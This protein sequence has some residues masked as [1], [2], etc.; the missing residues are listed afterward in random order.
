[1]ARAIAVM[2]AALFAVMQAAPAAARETVQYFSGG[3]K[4]VCPCFV[5][6][7]QIA[8]VFNAPASAYPIEITSVSVV[9]A[10]QFGVSGAFTERAVRLYLGT[11]PSLG[12]PAYSIDLPTLN[13]GSTNEFA[14][15]PIRVDAGSFTVALELA[16]SNAGMIFSP[17]VVH[18]GNGCHAGRNFV[19]TGGV[20]QDACAI[21]FTGD[22]EFLVSY[23]SL[24]PP[25]LSAAPAAVSLLD[26]P[27]NTTACATVVLANSG[28]DTLTIRG[29]AGCGNV[30]FAI[31]SSMTS[32]RL[33]PGGQTTLGICA[34]PH[35]VDPASCSVQIIHDRGGSVTIP[36]SCRPTTSVTV[37]RQPTSHQFR[38]K[39]VVPNPFNP[40]TSV[41]FELPSAMTVTAEVWS[42]KGARVRTLVRD[43]AFP[44]GDNS[45][46]W[47]GR[48]ANGRPVSSGVYLVR[49][50]TRAGDLVARAVLLE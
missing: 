7:D 23:R 17:S 44:E 30:T 25:A 49:I 10:A 41:N 38:L 11:P 13:A 15:G 24:V 29:I 12:V 1:V 8:V 27:L 18:D 46:R 2:L 43:M 3:G 36:V 6:G 31:D 16:N 33:P 28:V 42:V 32:H 37:V 34:T 39:G 48:N 45:I 35:T 9:W 26:V 14:V 20:W 50:R 22:W 19:L 5:A 47:D 40:Q 21:G 4:L